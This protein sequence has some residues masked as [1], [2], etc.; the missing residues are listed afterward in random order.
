[1]YICETGVVD[2]FT[3]C[4]LK[5]SKDLDILNITTIDYFCICYNA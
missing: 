1:M 2:K 3:D 5:T 4:F